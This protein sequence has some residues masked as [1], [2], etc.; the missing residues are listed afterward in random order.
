MPEDVFHIV[1]AAGV[2][3]AAIA[4]VVEAAVIMALYGR[5]KDLQAK[6]LPVIQK[7]ETAV[8]K[9]GPVIDRIGPVVD[10]VAP[11]IQ[12]VGPALEKVNQILAT[13]QRTLEEVRPY[14]LDISQE[15]AAVA[16][17]GREQME[18]V[19]ELVRDVGD[20]ARER[21]EQIDQTVDATVGQVGQVGENLKRAVTRPVRE[22]NGL[23]AGISAA[24]ST[25]VR[26]PRR[27][28]VDHATQ[29]EEMFI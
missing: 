19:S 1:V 23:A 8:A 14:V 18:R 15:A 5:V 3:L 10:Q 13:T 17:S 24:V 16:H 12:K 9:A 6:M 26:G 29:D 2:L 21:L 20:R 22:V 11:V 25:L 4:F 27:S 7:T 28:P